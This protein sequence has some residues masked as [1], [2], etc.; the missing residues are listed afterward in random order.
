MD[1]DNFK[2]INDTYGHDNGDKVILAI[3][4]YI[5]LINNDKHIFVARY[6]GEEFAFIFMNTPRHKV[7][8]KLQEIRQMISEYKF[9]FDNEKSIT[10]SCGLFECRTLTYSVEDVFN[11]A[12]KALYYAKEHGK[13]QLVVYNEINKE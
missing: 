7:V 1:I 13:N 4:K 12:D 3:A 10:M 9:D 5:R 2:S 11:N 8:E 6:G